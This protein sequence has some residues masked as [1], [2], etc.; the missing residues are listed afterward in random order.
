MEKFLEKGCLITDV[1]HDGKYLIGRIRGGIS[2]G[3]Y[4]ISVKEKS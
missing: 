3:I 4:A 1:T 2:A